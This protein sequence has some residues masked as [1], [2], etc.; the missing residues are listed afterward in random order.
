MQINIWELMEPLNAGRFGQSKR[1]HKDV[2]TKG[3]DLSFP[4]KHGRKETRQAAGKGGSCVI[5][6]AKGSLVR[7]DIGTET[8]SSQP[9]LHL[10]KTA[11]RQWLVKENHFL[12]KFRTLLV[13]PSEQHSDFTLKDMEHWLT[14]TSGHT[15]GSLNSAIR[16][17]FL[18]K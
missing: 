17:N 12:T 8:K 2:D 14:L 13:A 18:V 11:K 9:S 4:G 3:E 16:K 5:Q 15:Q 1:M 7:S 6:Q 10:C